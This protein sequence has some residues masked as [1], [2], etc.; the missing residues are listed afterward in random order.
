MYCGCLIVSPACLQ[1]RDRGDDNRQ[2]VSTA[3]TDLSQKPGEPG[4]E[5]NINVRASGVERILRATY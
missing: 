2:T 1:H 4:T 3:R 5:E